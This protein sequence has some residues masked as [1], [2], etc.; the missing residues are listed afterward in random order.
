MSF[1]RQVP[2]D[3]DALGDE[4]SE[5]CE[6]LQEQKLLP[7]QIHFHGYKLCTRM[8]LGMLRRYDHWPL[9]MCIHSEI[10]ENCP[11][12]GHDFIAVQAAIR[13]ASEEDE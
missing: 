4:I 8:K 1:C 10:M 6:E 9:P 11:D 5:E 2:C 12:P 3:W 13:L 7:N